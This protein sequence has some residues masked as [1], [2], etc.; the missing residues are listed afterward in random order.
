MFRYIVAFFFFFTF[1]FSACNNERIPVEEQPPVPQDEIGI[2]EQQADQTAQVSDEE[3]EMF[4]EAIL[5]AEE[6]WVDPQTQI[7]EMEPI[8]TEVGLS[9]DR[10]QEIQRI[11]SD[12]PQLRERIEAA[13]DE[14]RD[15]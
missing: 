12:D 6:E 8:V 5:K 2:T 11:S 9:L 7:S 4:V 1:S 15:E 13:M 3:V 14:A 10:F